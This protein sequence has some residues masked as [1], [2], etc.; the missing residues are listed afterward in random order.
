MHARES[1][2]RGVDIGFTDI[3]AASSLWE[4]PSCP[5]WALRARFSF[6]VAMSDGG[7]TGFAA[8]FSWPFL[9]EGFTHAKTERDKLIFGGS[10]YQLRPCERREGQHGICVRL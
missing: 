1:F 2:C 6:S 10:N 9:H 4:S 7:G 3:L 5:T 8:F